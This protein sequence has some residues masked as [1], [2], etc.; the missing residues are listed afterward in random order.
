MD[1]LRNQLCKKPSPFAA[2]PWK[3]GNLFS[4]NQAENKAISCD[5]ND[6]LDM[7]AGTCFDK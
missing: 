7:V 1:S 6:V 4:N 5:A 2:F 3:F